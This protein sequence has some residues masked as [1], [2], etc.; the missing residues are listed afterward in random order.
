MK[1]PLHILHLEDDLNDADLVRYALEADGITFTITRVQTR[2]DFVAALEGGG[3]DLILSDFDLPAFDGLS[4]AEIVRTRWS[5]IPLILVSGS[6][7]EELTIDSFKTGA[8]DCVPKR[9]LSRL[10]PAVRRAMREVEERVERRRLEAQVIESQKLEL[11][12]Q[13]SSGVA[14]DFN[15]LLAVILGYSDLIMSQFGE[16]STLR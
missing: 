10:G 14:H 2:N 15:N 7:D 5:E 13:L 11:I 16:N 1:S 9:D 8:T 12:S 6:L 3:I 4:A